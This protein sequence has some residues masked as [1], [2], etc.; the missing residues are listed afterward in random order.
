ME[1][2]YFAIWLGLFPFV[3]SLIEYFRAK[4]RKNIPEKYNDLYAILKIVIWIAG[5]Y[6]LY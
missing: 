1:K 5:G 3:V 4:K 6:L 2:L